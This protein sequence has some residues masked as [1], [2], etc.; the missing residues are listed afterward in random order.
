MIDSGR[1]VYII[2]ICWRP[3]AS[4]GY[5][6]RSEIAHHF[7][8]FGS[9]DLLEKEFN[10]FHVTCLDFH[11]DS[12]TNINILPVGTQPPVRLVYIINTWLFPHYVGFV[13]MCVCVDRNVVDRQF[14]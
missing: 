10:I 6:P 11:T 7:M 1:F 2:Y 12:T 8:K 4:T 5:P 13:C 14:I 3:A 9:E